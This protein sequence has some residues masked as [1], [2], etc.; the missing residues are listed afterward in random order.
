VHLILECVRQFYGESRCFRILG[1][2]G[3]YRYLDWSNQGIT[4]RVI[5]ELSDG[6]PVCRRPIFD[7]DV[8]AEKKDPYTR[9]SHNET[10]KDLYNMGV[11]DPQ[12]AAAASILLSGMDFSGVGRVREQVAAL[13]RA[14]KETDTVTS[15]NPEP[16]TSR[17]PLARA[18]NGAV[19]LA[20]KAEKEVGA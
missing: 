12:N 9:F 14:A 13:A 2:N 4:E 7:I 17:D 18:V 15:R 19:H 20:A 10:M 11:F 3:D 1:E 5:G 8:R 6:T 16:S